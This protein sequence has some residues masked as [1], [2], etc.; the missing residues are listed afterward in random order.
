MS[1]R[2]PLAAVLAWI[3]LA[4]TTAP[5]QTRPRPRTPA[6]PP[7]PASA[8]VAPPPVVLTGLDKLSRAY[9]A[10][11]DADFERA[12]TLVADACPPAP[13]EACL[14]LEATRQLWRIQ[15]DPEDR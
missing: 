1:L 14:V 5:A 13:R 11:F 8:P 4:G 10:I 3:V 6:A 2:R 9:A 15:I 12:R 7:P